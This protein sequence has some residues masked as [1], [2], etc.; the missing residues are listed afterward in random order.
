[1]NSFDGDVHWQQPNVGTTKVNTNVALFEDS[2]CY[3][4][5]MLA[6]DQEGRKIEAV[7][8]CKERRFNPEFAETIGI[9]EALSWVKLK[10]WPVV[11][12][13][14]DCPTAIQAIHCSSTNLSYIGRVIDE[15]K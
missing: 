2:N 4:Y 6:R 7:S 12:V 13:E 5:A 14:T 9:R 10:Q 8:C 3:S 11:V 15:C 1:M